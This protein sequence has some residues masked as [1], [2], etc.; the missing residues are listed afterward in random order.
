[1]D[2][3]DVHVISVYWKETRERQRQSRTNN[4]NTTTTQ[5][6]LHFPPSRA[7]RP[8]KAPIELAHQVSG[9]RK[10]LQFEPLFVASA[11]TLPTHLVLR[12]AV[13]DALV[14]QLLNLDMTSVIGWGRGDG[15]RDEL[16]VVGDM[17]LEKLHIDDGVATRALQVEAIGI[18]IDL[19]L[20]LVGALESTLELTCHILVRRVELVTDSHKISG[21]ELFPPPPLVGR[22]GLTVLRHRDVV[23]DQLGDGR[24]P[25]GESIDVRVIDRE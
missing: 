22:S 16:R 5:T 10:V 17:A 11:V 2:D 19:L 21:L 14:Q 1:M 20:D 6:R 8:L 12:F 18:P 13:A 25:A 23:L 24:N 15:A 3:D 4:N 9:V 7:R